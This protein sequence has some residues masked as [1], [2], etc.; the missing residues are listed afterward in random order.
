MNNK[1]VVICCLVLITSMALNYFKVIDPELMK[2]IWGVVGP[3][4]LAAIGLKQNAIA[5]QTEA[6]ATEV[7]EIRSR[8]LMPPEAKKE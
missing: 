7:K 4:F 6:T 2:A 5:T 8:M 3:V 1:A